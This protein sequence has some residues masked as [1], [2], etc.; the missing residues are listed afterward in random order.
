MLLN[1]ARDI[2]TMTNEYT[3]RS[4]KTYSFNSDGMIEINNQRYCAA[5]VSPEHAKQASF[6]RQ[7]GFETAKI[8]SKLREHECP[9]PGGR[10]VIDYRGQLVCTHTIISRNPAFTESPP[11][12]SLDDTVAELIQSAQDAEEVE[13]TLAEESPSA[14][15]EPSQK[16]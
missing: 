2:I 12:R 9:Y 1:L 8:I 10:V 15:E 16:A 4:G 6:L 11:R 7:G 13:L 5:Y 14:Q 3:D